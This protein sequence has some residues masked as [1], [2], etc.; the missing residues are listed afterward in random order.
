MAIGGDRVAYL[1]RDAN[2]VFVLDEGGGP[3]STHAP[4]G[5]FVVQLIYVSK[6]EVAFE[7]SSRRPRVRDLSVSDREVLRVPFDP[8]R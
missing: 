6:T 4:R 7:V 1:D 5:K 2:A 3:R 8:A